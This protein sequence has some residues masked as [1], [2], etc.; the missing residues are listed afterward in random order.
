ME[1][2]GLLFKKCVYAVIFCGALPLLL[3]FWSKETEAIIS[4]PVPDLPYIAILL[5]LLGAGL[6]LS[7]MWGLW[8]KGKGLPMNA[9]PPKFYVKTGAYRL[10]RHPIYIGAILV[11]I[12][13]SL[14]FRSSSGLWLVSPLFC[15]LI[16]MYILGFE[17]EVMEQHFADAI[18][19]HQPLCSLPSDSPNPLS[20]RQKVAIFIAV[21]GSWLLIYECFIYFGNPKD[22]FLSEISLDSHIPLIKF[23]VIFYNLLYPM[24]I[25]LPFVLKSNQQGKAFVLD[26]FVGM[27]IIFY[28]Y[29]TIPAVLNYQAVNSDS[30]FAKWIIWGRSTD[31]ETGALPSFHVFWALICYR[32]YK[33]QFSAWK[34][35]L[36]TLTLLIILSCLTTKNHTLLDVIAGILAYLLTIYRQP[37]YLYLLK[38]CE[39]ISNSWREWHFGRV[40]I[41]N[42]GFYA[43]AG[44]FCGFMIM[45]YF[46]P[47]QLWILYAIGIAG[48]VG[49]GLWAQFVEGSP[50]LLRPFGYYGSVI[51][52][53]IVIAIISL[54]SDIEV[55]YLT[56]IAALAASPIQFWG[57]FRCLV[58]G[59]CHG[60]PTEI[61]GI[62]FHH[63]KSRVHKLAGWKGV[64]LYPTQFYSIAANFFTFFILWRFVRLEMPLTFITG[65]YL[66]LNGAFRFVEESLRGE[67]QTPYFLGIRVY[68]W[69]ALLSI[70]AGIFCTMVPSSTLI[71]GTLSLT[72]WLNGIIYF[73]IILFAYGIDFP[74]S[75]VRFSRLTQE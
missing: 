7:A 47:D 38:G 10:F 50:L 51:G 21:F 1:K 15:V 58:Q 33:L 70:L 73:G 22:A 59:C 17:R 72:L 48:F 24:A 26:S 69:L 2:L 61:A 30:F 66:I 67:P 31:G 37:I 44:G 28:C 14:Y 43:A 60:K 29:L 13:L 32:Y 62:C 35:P 34:R 23:S 75:N 6:M 20:L 49:A 54:F 19:A 3:W 42:H 68:Q 63:P 65:M 71:H 41:I 40:R 53:A 55:W 39:R 52:V 45:G 56:A 74:H 57:R 27:V 12:G 9:Y 4:L 18:Q 5:I 64:N 8:F 11:C 25:I 46:L 36:A 16:T